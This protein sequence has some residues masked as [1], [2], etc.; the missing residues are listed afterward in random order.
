MPWPQSM[1][2]PGA[3]FLHIM[4]SQIAKYSTV[5]VSQMLFVYKPFS[6]RLRAEVVTRTVAVNPNYELTAATGFV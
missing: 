5:L 6:G 3:A 2:Y 1:S 4:V